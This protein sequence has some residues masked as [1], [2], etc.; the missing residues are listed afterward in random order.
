MVFDGS[1]LYAP[2]PVG[3]KLWCQHYTTLKFHPCKILERKSRPQQSAAAS[4]SA[5]ATQSL[6][7]SSSSSVVRSLADIGGTGHLPA[8]LA[9]LAQSLASHSHLYYIH[10]I[11]WDRR[12]D[13]WTTRD[14]LL[15][16]SQIEQIAQHQRPAQ[17]PAQQPTQP[18]SSASPSLPSDSQQA[19]L[20][21]SEPA[22]ASSSLPSQSLDTEM[23][24]R[25]ESALN[26][27]PAQPQSQ[28]PPSASS[29]SLSAL[30]PATSPSPPPIAA[31]SSSA[32]VDGLLVAADSHA[33]SGSM[34]G[35]HGNFS[36]DDLKAHEEATKVKN[37]DCIT[38]G[39][40]SMST[41]YYSPFPP[42][43]S[44]FS[45][46]HF[47]EYCLCFFGHDSELQ[48]HARRCVLRHPPGYEIYRSTERNC[49]VAMFEVDGARETV[50]CQNLCYLA[51]LFLDHKTLEF[52]ATPFLFYVLCERDQTEEKGY[53]VVGYFSKEKVSATGY[54]LA[55]SAASTQPA[56]TH[57]DDAAADVCLRCSACVSILTLPCHQRKGY[58]KLLIS[59]SYELS[60]I[61]EKVGSPEKPISDLG[62]V[63]YMS[64]WTETLLAC[65]Q[66]YL[67]AAS[68]AAAN[69]SDAA[70]ATT[71]SGR[72]AQTDSGSAATTRQQLT[73]ASQQQPS[74]SVSPVPPG[75]S[76]AAGSLQLS[77]SSSSSSLSQSGDASQSQSSAAVSMSDQSRFP[78][79]SV[80]ELSRTTCITCDDIIECLKA[81]NVLLWYGG[82]WVWSESTLRRLLQ[83]REDKRR[84]KDRKERERRAAG[85][86][87]DSKAIFVSQ[88]RPELLHWTPFFTPS[89]RLKS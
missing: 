57:R 60:K 12:M 84:E 48:R 39:P 17:Q 13:E 31:A 65:L 21:L 66:H 53:H 8:P 45:V 25:F 14:R 56:L 41:W 50:Y 28:L 88:C 16:P 30:A 61:E 54:N 38:F 36:E 5:A 27:Q 29:N 9:A 52:D 19:G 7:S 73:R 59:I 85:V 43:Y 77:Q 58:G 86:V 78:C 75:S 24:E 40:Y 35:G 63:S 72:A 6:A 11:D 70:A 4:A 87:D 33:A 18:A 26:L 82:R 42:E 69:G 10:Y 74:P 22:S 80:E 68:A 89:R 47:C 49:T 55:W 34:V 44:R 83:E 15:L 3:L 62:K 51:K 2:L 46:L 71:S 67:P 1:D 76:A 20:E 23:E 79:V 32:L 81:W 37:V 64:Y